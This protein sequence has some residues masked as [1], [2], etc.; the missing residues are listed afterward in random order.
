[1]PLINQGARHSSYTIS[2]C[3]LSEMP[4]TTSSWFARD[5]V[6]CR[7]RHCSP[8]HRQHPLSEPFWPL[9]SANWDTKHFCSAGCLCRVRGP[10][11]HSHVALED[12]VVAAMPPKMAA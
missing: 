5:P 1:V 8:E 4:R 6:I 10:C 3:H 7:P 11:G 12:V 2:L 9:E